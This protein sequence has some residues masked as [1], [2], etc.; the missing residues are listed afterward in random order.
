M[1]LMNYSKDKLSESKPYTPYYPNGEEMDAKIFL[2]SI[3]SSEVLKEIDR[4][5]KRKNQGAGSVER[6]TK[7][8]IDVCCVI[9]DAIE[10]FTIEEEENTLGFELEGN[11]V[12]STDKNIRLLMENFI[13]LREQVSAQAADDSFFY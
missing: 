1:N 3:K 6:A 2:K 11:K 9:V 10:G 8:D 5:T 12:V 7:A 13:F 4:V